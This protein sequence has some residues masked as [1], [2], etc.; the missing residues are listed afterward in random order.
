MD[1]VGVY[2]EC[3]NTRIQDGW[4]D[5]RM[6]PHLYPAFFLPRFSANWLSASLPAFNS[7]PVLFF[8]PLFLISFYLLSQS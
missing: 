8:S 1:Y 5:G 2:H 4:M 7:P 3:D 6:E